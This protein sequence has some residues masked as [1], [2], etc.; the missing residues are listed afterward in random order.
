MLV[1]VFTPFSIT[2]L[3]QIWRNIYIRIVDWEL[4]DFSILHFFSRTQKKSEISKKVLR[5]QIFLRTQLFFLKS[6]FSLMRLLIALLW[7][8]TWK[9]ASWGSSDV[10]KTFHIA[11]LGNSWRFLFDQKWSSSLKLCFQSFIW[12]NYKLHQL[13]KSEIWNVF[14]TSLE[15][16][17][18][19]L[20]SV[21]SQKCDQKPRKGEKRLL[22]KAK[23]SEIFLRSQKKNQFSRIKWDWKPFYSLSTAA[24]DE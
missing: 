6:M 12:S 5:T 18:A 11:E 22:K 14:Q 13:P 24:A 23:F 15:P 2:T 10:W 16:Q 3:H 20:S 21:L 8:H 7:Q 1:E 19:N 4:N 9:L 17:D